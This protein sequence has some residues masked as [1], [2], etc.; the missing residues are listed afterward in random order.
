MGLE[1]IAVAGL[2]L[3]GVSTVANMKASKDQSSAQK[4]A[5]A[6][7]RRMD[8]LRQNRERRQAI[9]EQRIKTAQVI[10]AGA[11]QGAQTSSA[12]QGGA[13]S[14]QSQ[15]SSNLSFLD[16]M[17]TNANLA[18]RANQQAL[19]AGA[20]AQTWGAMAGLGGTIFSQAG[21]FQSIFGSGDI[22]T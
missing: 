14:L 9:R 13:G 12:V 20:R 6:Y 2:V 10:Q 1:T 21:G 15:L 19:N 4:K 22:K 11:N 17:A 7:Q 18:S 16:N 8:E 3:S 5:A